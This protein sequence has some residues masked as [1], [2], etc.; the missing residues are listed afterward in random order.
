MTRTEKDIAIAKLIE[1]IN[2]SNHFYLTDISDLNAID[3]NNLRS[4]CF[5]KGIELLV[6]KNTLLQKALMNSKVK[7]SNF[8]ILKGHT[9]IMFTEH[10]S[11]PAKLIKE[12][13]KKASK[14]ILKAAYV[15]ESIYIGDNQLDALSTIKSK[16]ELIGD[17]LVILQTPINNVI[18]AL[19]TGNNILTGVLKTLADK[20]VE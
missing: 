17:I 13:R 4:L 7:F 12:F 14:P 1:K 5:K 15:E 3:T 18:S 16:E 10:N 8:E 9:S 2:K 20:K 6:V 11:T 19:K